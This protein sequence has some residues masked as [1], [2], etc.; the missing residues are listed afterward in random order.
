MT[1]GWQNP[2]A[3]SYPSQRPAGPEYRPQSNAKPYA[4]FQAFSNPYQMPPLPGSNNQYDGA[5]L[6]YGFAPNITACNIPNEQ[7]PQAN[8][9]PKGPS[10]GWAF[11]NDLTDGCAQSTPAEDS[12]VEKQVEIPCQAIIV[13]DEDMP[14]YSFGNPSVSCFYFNCDSFF[15][16]RKKRSQSHII[17]M[18]YVYMC[19]Y[20]LSVFICSIVINVNVCK[21]KPTVDYTQYIY[22]WVFRCR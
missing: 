4:G 17:Q 2:S 1:A 5:R 21:L 12:P 9:Q 13:P 22:E 15:F 3:L 19:A 14:I 11:Q 16:S 20:V 18:S 8:T 10:I 7:K 6:S